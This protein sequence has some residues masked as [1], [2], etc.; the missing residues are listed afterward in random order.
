MKADKASGRRDLLTSPTFVF[1]I[2]TYVYVYVC[3]CVY[4]YSSA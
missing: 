1:V 4:V 3:V 2:C